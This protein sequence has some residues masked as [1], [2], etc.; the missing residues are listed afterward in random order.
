MILLLG[1]SGYI[2][3]FFSCELRRRGCD[4]IPLTRKAFDYSDFNLLFNFVRKTR[5]EFVINAAG[6]A[7]K[8]GMEICEHE[9]AAMLFANTL[10]PQTIAKVCLMTNTPWGHVSSACIYSGAKVRNDGSMTVERNFS[11]PELLRLLAEHPEN[12][13]GYT[14]WDEPNFSFR[15]APCNFYSGTKVLAE[16]AIQG[17]GLNYI[18]RLGTPFNERDESRNFLSQIQNQTKV[19]DDVI[20]LSH[21]NDFVQACLELWKRR[22]PFG[23]YNVTNPGSVTTRQVAEMI[24]HRLKPNGGFEF[25]QDDPEFDRDGAKKPDTHCLID[26]AKLL[27]TGVKIR[28]VTEALE[29][30]LQNWR[31]ATPFTELIRTAA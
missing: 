10:L 20:S 25:W 8:P 11:R 17:V 14:E 16:E 13:R 21:T 29:E 27:A 1:A 30:A 3:Q 12:V 15:H 5:P 19:Y 18:W 28:P 26:T 24:Q 9:R 23:I 2:G 6:R 31:A 22:A 4:F 7:G